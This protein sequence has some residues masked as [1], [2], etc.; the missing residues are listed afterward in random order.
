[1]WDTFSDLALVPFSIPILVMQA[2]HPDV[3]AA[4]AR[5]SV[6]RQEPWSRLFRTGFSLM[7]FMYGG[8]RG[9]QGRREARDL[10]RLHAHIK[11]VRPDGGEYFALTP[12][13]FR[14]VP[15][16]F[17]AGVIRFREEMA[18]PLSAEEKSRLFAEYLDLCRLFRI[19][20][21]ELED[22]LEQFQIYFD[23]LLLETMTY[24]ETVAFLLEEMMRQGPRIPC[25]PQAIYRRGLYPLIRLFTLG[26]LDPRFRRQHGIRWSARDERN[27]RRAVAVVRTFRRITPRWLRYSPFSLFIM[28]GGQGPRVITFE[29]L[30]K[31][32]GWR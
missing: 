26:F 3:G 16:T 2:A 5:Y 6:Y 17:L 27:Y 18:D 11:G 19:P 30:K 15:D 24:N 31:L 10:R 4:V 9:E 14:V 23:R 7:R 21:G 25:L 20:R 32:K 22:D 13:T 12:S 8:K 28:L 1:M 29:R